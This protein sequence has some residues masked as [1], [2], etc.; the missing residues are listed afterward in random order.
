MIPLLAVE[1][2]IPLGILVEL[3]MLLIEVIEV[4]LIVLLIDELVVDEVAKVVVDPIEVT[5]NPTRDPI[6]GETRVL[7]SEGLDAIEYSVQELR[8]STSAML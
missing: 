8:A 6:C 2:L 3:V 7:G 5:L 4:T 1:R